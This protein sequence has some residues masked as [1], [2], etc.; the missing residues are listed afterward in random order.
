MQIHVNQ[1]SWD[2]EINSH[3]LMVHVV[4]LGMNVNNQMD[5]WLL[6]LTNVVMELV[7]HH[8]FKVLKKKVALQKFHVQNPNLI[9]VEMENVQET[10]VFVEFR[11]RAHN[12]ME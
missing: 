10:D 4:L 7:L 1:Y 6:I 5:A 9:Y 2:V 12:P 11:Y 3:V 8:Q